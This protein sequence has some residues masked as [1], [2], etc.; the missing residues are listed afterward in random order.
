MSSIITSQDQQLLNKFHV[1][2]EVDATS[3]CGIITIDK[4]RLAVTLLT[5][6]AVKGSNWE[7]VELDDESMEETAKKVAV[8]LLKKD[9]LQGKQPEPLNFKINAKGIAKTSAK[10]FHKHEDT[11]SKK[12]TRK[13]FDA[14]DGYLN[15]ALSKTPRLDTEDKEIEEGELESDSPVQDKE[16]HQD[17]AKEIIALTQSAATKKKKKKKKTA[18][19]ESE[20]AETTV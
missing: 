4:R 8:M 1:Q 12:N 2:I 5:C 7:P 10:E 18:S 3:H 15:D 11:N 14:L 13:D 19:I 16:D 9:F 6:A 17:L 20:D